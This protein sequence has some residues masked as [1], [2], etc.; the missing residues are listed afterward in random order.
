MRLLATAILTS[1]SLLAARAADPP[2]APR[3]SL[4][5]WGIVAGEE[6]RSTGIADPIGAAISEDARLAQRAQTF[7][8]PGYFDRAAPLREAVLM[9]DPD[10]AGQDSGETHF[11]DAGR[12]AK[13]AG[14]L[15]SLIPEALRPHPEMLCC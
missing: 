7:A 10:A 8:S 12:L 4:D 14:I 15:E 6:V 1:T 13:A 3:A 2:S 9:I 11:N 5:R